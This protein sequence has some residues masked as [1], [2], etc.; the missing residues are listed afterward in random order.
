MT[1]QGSA[2]GP[3]RARRLFLTNLERSG[4]VHFGQSSLRKAQRGDGEGD[5]LA[6]SVER[7]V[8][9]PELP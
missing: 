2:A 7:V 1:K 5:R 3:A 6:T 8:Q 4:P 9:R